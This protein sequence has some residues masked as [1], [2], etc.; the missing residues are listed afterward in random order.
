M[1]TIYATTAEA[2]DVLGVDKRTVVRM[3][4]DG[5]L[6]PAL[7]FPTQTGGYQFERAEITCA[8]AEQARA[9]SA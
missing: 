9:A 5:R 3:V 6:T 2:A 7:K 1:T 4:E 8:K